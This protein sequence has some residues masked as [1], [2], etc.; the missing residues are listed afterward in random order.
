MHM[1]EKYYSSDEDWQKF[2]CLYMREF[3]SR[4]EVEQ[5]SKQLG[6][7][8][9]LACVIYGLMGEAEADNWIYTKVPM[10]DDIKAVDCINDPQLLKR[11]RVVL[12]R[13][14]C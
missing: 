5:L 14:P 3:S 13:F 10:L 9:D 6:D 12:I 11:L 8:L 1:L 7:Q 2:S 4:G